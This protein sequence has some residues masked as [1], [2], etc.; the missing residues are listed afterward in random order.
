MVTECNFNFAY[1]LTPLLLFYFIVL[2][3]GI[4]DL[5]TFSS[6]PSPSS[7]ELT[8]RKTHHVLIWLTLPSWQPISSAYLILLKNHAI[9][10]WSIYSF[11]QHLFS[12][13]TYD[14]TC[15]IL[16]LNQ[17]PWG[18]L[19]WKTLKQKEK[20]FVNP[21]HDIYLLMY[22][23]YTHFFCFSLDYFFFYLFTISFSTKSF[24]LA[25][26]MLPFLQS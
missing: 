17:W 14:T 3:W 25:P 10:L 7:N 21:C 5:V 12:S 24:S 2:F 13:Q 1:P 16:S 22:N 9:F 8:W 4:T 23:V 18:S 6:A 26:R 19:H 20:N 15:P 11:L